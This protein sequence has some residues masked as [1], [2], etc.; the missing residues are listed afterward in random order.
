MRRKMLGMSQQNLAAALGITFQQIQKYEKGANRIGASRLQK[1]SEVLKVPISY[2]FDGW[3]G[4]APSAPIEG[5]HSELS[6]I[7]NFMASSDG[8][9]LIQAF[10]RIKSLSLRRQLTQLAIGIADQAD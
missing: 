5:E 8:I 10:V 1:L 2:F 7:T 3:P 4:D 6:D 9:T